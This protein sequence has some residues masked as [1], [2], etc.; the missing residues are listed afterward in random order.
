MEKARCKDT[1]A[2][3]S[4]VLLLQCRV[5]LMV[6]AY[7]CMGCTGAKGRDGIKWQ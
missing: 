6:F 7:V 3:A 2:F 1:T 4:V 5:D